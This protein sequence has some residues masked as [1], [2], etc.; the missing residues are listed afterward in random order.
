MLSGNKSNYNFLRQYLKEEQF[1]GL[2]E[3][4]N[5]YLNELEQLFKV[6]LNR[7]VK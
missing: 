6:K 2:T 1:C 4:D 5:I 3:I 7:K